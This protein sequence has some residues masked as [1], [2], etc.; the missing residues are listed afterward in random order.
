MLT[1]LDVA[2]QPL[3]SEPFLNPSLLS[4]PTS[5]IGQVGM[6]L[7]LEVQGSCQMHRLDGNHV[8]QGVG[9]QSSWLTSPSAKSYDT[10][11]KPLSLPLPTTATPSRVHESPLGITS[12]Y[13]FP[14]LAC[15]LC[16]SCAVSV[17]FSEPWKKI[18]K[19]TFFA[20]TRLRS[21]GTPSQVINCAVSWLVRNE[22]P[23]PRQLY[24][25]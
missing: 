13:H 4:S 12:R 7:R 9:M 18:V 8:Q 21:D 1:S 25:G 2:S 3:A 6:S 5:Q 22:T 10:S 19:G 17:G 14:V 23:G 24:A 20:V 15:A 16:V 11:S